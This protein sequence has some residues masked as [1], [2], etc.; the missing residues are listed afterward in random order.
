MEEIHKDGAVFLSSSVINGRFVIRMAILA[1]RT[2][3]ETIDEA[4][5]MIQRCLDRVVQA[6]GDAA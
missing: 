3:K 1:F 5:E 2:K 4:V 6:T